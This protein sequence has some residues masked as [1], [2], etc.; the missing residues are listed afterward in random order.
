MPC[1]SLPRGGGGT[2]VRPRPPAQLRAPGAISRSTVPPPGK[3]TGHAEP[4]HRAGR[5]AEPPGAFGTP[6]APPTSQIQ[7]C[8]LHALPPAPG[9]SSAWLGGA[10]P[11]PGTRVL[12]WPWG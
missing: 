8:L 5:P 10:M 2:S 12:S 3:A 6:G 7:P 9:S 1:P 4:R 11:S